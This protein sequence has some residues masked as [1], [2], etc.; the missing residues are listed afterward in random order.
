MTPEA[1][2]MAEATGASASDTGDR[3]PIRPMQVLVVEDNE[4]NRTV[5]RDMLEAGG[6]A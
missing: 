6:H 4:I 3:G 2:H 1:R 5:A